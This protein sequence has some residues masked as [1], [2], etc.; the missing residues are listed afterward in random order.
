MEQ[1]PSD[2]PTIVLSTINYNELSPLVEFMYSGEVA[3]DQES[4]PKLLEAANIL[5]I[6]GLYE[7]PEE[8]K[9]SEE[10][11]QEAIGNS[12]GFQ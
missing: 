9:V 5:Q 3:V 10:S 12:L 4:L 11:K 7:A 6:K 8:S 1:N 2:H